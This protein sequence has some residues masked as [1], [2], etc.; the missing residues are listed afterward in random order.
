[1]RLKTSFFKR[2]T[3]AVA[4]Q[5]LGKYLC[6]RV[7]GKVVCVRITETEAYCGTKD[8]AC[9]ASKGLTERTKVMFGPPGCAYVYLIYG[10]HHCFNV[11][12]REVGYPEAVLVRSVEVVK[13]QNSTFVPNSGRGKIKRKNDNSKFKINGPGRVC[14][15]LS[16]DKNL[17]GVD[18][19]LS[20]ELWI[21]DGGE[22]PPR[23]KQGK[24]I[25]IEYAGKW[26]DKLWRFS[27]E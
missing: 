12:T 7:N 2:S 5:L 18:V 25:G 22:K 13:M 20:K 23:I 10:M 1:M 16:I 11:V 9:H 15:N 14:K 24:R 17:N 8:K 19:C 6:R 4:K 3:I 26:K 21:E 27:L